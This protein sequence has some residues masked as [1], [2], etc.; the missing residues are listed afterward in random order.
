MSFRPCRHLNKGKTLWTAGKMIYDKVRIDNFA[1]IAEKLENFGFGY[2]IR[3]IAYK[4]FQ[5]AAPW[6]L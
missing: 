4:E 3:Q 1:K 2:I 5:A 6:G